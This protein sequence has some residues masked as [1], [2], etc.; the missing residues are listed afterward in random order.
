MPLPTRSEERAVAFQIVFVN[1]SLAVPPAV[2]FVD[3]PSPVDPAAVVTRV[4]HGSEDRVCDG[5]R[6]PP[7]REPSGRR[8]RE[9]GR[10]GQDQLPRR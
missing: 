2:V 5:G 10:S 3:S 1:I 9:C 6:Q 7:A 8:V 4:E